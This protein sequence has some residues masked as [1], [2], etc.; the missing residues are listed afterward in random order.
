MAHRSPVASAELVS[1]RSALKTAE[2]PKKSPGTPVHF[3]NE[4]IEVRE[5]D[6]TRAERQGKKDAWRQ[7]GVNLEKN[8]KEKKAEQKRQS[9][10]RTE[11]FSPPKA[12]KGRARPVAESYFFRK[13]R[14]LGGKGKAPPAGDGL[15]KRLPGFYCK[16][17]K[18]EIEEDAEFCEDCYEDQANGRQERDKGEAFH[19]K[20]YPTRWL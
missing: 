13:C 19:C 15:Q 17:C 2:S 1:L 11:K 18:D 12:I 8:Y 5:Y 14:A 10:R 3:G 7:I 6:M 4:W 20:E 16:E 9:R